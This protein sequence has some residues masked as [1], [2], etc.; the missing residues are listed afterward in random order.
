MM[1]LTLL[2]GCL[3]RNDIPEPIQ[4]RTKPVDKPELILPKADELIQRKIEWI[5]V[6][7]ENHKESF[8]ELKDKG[9]PLVFFGLTDQGYENISLNLSDIQMYVSQQHAIVDAYE[10]YYNQAES[11]LDMAVTLE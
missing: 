5:L 1:I 11:K 4:I 8:A 7:P 10:K 2:T 3:G 9:R 6:T